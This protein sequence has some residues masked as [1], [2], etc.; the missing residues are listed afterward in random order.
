M[1]Q[2]LLVSRDG[3]VLRVVLNRPEVRNAFND[4]LIGDLRRVADE[5]AA[6]DGVRVVVLSGSGAA[7]C[8]GGD[9]AWMARAVQLD[10][11]ANEEEAGRMAAMFEALDRLPA[12]LVGRVHG[13][14]LGGGAGLAA[15]CDV[16]VAASDAVFGFTEV[17]L[18]LV[19]SVIAP[20]ALAKIGRAAARH[21]FLTGTRF[22]AARA[23]EIGLVHEVV[24]A[25][26]L[27]EAVEA[28]VRDLRSAGPQAVAT[29]KQLIRDV[30]PLGT[31]D[32]ARLTTQI[33]ADRRVSS[34]GQEGLR[35][36]LAKRRP[37]WAGSE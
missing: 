1:F 30:W 37:R 3:P 26:R 4:E 10:R 12:A 14:A 8:A 32:A 36:F 7:F 5:A 11:D 22:G 28:V 18:G 31:R 15:V 2:H 17:R 9:L 35:A 13:H 33:I 29:A 25:E 19:P 27:D 6:D 24:P 21:L 20:Y 16:V 23:R 34:E